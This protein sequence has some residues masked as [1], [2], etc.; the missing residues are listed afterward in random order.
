MTHTDV[1]LGSSESGS[2]TL[3]EGDWSSVFDNDRALGIML[4][5][6]FS[7][8]STLCISQTGPN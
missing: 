1:L 7:R 4:G 8:H 5:E 2:V 3:T 6:E